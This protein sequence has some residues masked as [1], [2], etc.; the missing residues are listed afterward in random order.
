[1]TALLDAPPV[2]LGRGNGGFAARRAVVRWAWRLFRREWRQQLLVLALL[3]VAVAGA[4]VAEAVGP[5][6]SASL[7]G[8]FGTANYRAHLLGNDQDVAADVAAA[9]ERFGTVEVIATRKVPVPGSVGTIDLRAQDPNGSYGHVMLRLLA[10]RYPTAPG[11]VAVNDR[12][13]RIFD[14]RIGDDWHEGDQTLR[15]VGRVENP[16]DLLDTFAL[17][18]P[19]QAGPGGE[20]SVLLRTSNSN[21]HDF[22]FPKGPVAVEGRPLREK[23]MAA[24]LMLILSTVGLLFVGLVAVAGFTVLAQRRLRALGMLRSLG[25]TD[26]HIRLAMLANGAAV[27]AAA[28]VVGTAGGLA[29]WLALAPRLETVI[30]RRVDRFDLP[31]WAIGAAMVLAV[32]TSVGAAWWP[33]RAA[34]RIPVVGALSGRPPRPRPAHHS[35]ALGLGLLLAGPILLAF[36]HQ[37]RTL[38]IL[39]GIVA[40]TLGILLLA[41]LAIRA[42]AAVARRAP[43]AVRLAV[44][45][46]ARYQARSGAALGAVTLATGIAATIAVSATASQAQT[47]ETS[48]GN[49]PANQLLVR[50]GPEGAPGQPSITQAQL[51]A[52][53]ASVDAMAASLRA[54]AVLALDVAVDPSGP[55]IPAL[56]GRAGGKETAQLVKPIQ[57]PDGRQGYNLVGGLYVAT[58]AV[59]QHYGIDP[60]GVDPSADVISSQ[61]LAGLGLAYGPRVPLH[62][63]VQRLPLPTYSSAPNSLLTAHG[64]QALGLQAVPGGWLIET[65]T[66]LTTAQV[67]AAEKAAAAGGFT[68]ESRPSGSSLSRLRND[69]TG[70]G[71][72]VAFGVLAMTVG[73]IRSETVGDLRVLSAAGATSTTRRTLTGA[74]AGALA[75][76]GALLGTAG[77]YVA[78]VAWHHSRLH[79]LTHPPITDLVV[80]LVGMPVV[81]AAAGW[82]LAGRQPSAIARRPLE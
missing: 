10:G 38:F 48:G 64:L 34:A 1:M 6:A 66:D 69:A 28:A 58:P 17:V 26:R 47:D 61:S 39:G 14:L 20:V 57:M 74:T 30:D 59:L 8:S 22:R 63:K 78:L 37:R 27:G 4:T 16:A 82:L 12:A 75:L 67:D 52:V 19:G 29:G 32:V 72:L 62:P 71:V 53:Q 18:A 11:E 13:A 24:V 50:V 21:F 81:A 73:L 51:E 7:D 65:P 46:L 35:A 3:V 23:R 79:P 70:V 76:L 68:V 42:L 56:G 33:A 5:S 43:V 54:R 15:V 44:R 9:R 49:L 45:D 55:D 77:A 40:I 60:A 36:A 2:D 25:A 80:L 31:W 41:P